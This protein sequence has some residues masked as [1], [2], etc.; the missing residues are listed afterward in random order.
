MK[1]DLQGSISPLGSQQDYLYV[2]AVCRYKRQWLLVRHRQRTT[3]EGAGGH[4]EPGE[5]PLAAMHREL[6]EE[7]GASIYTLHAVCDYSAAGTH[8]VLFF[9]D[10]SALGP[11]PQSEIAEVALF[12]HLPDPQQLTYPGIF[13][14]VFGHICAWLA[15]QES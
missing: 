6:Y 4:I 15:E 11:L 13:P 9:A 5:T 7:T 10:I 2:V 8:G 1:Q 12:D 3:W 14:V